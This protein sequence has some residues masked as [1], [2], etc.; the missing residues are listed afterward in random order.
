MYSVLN[1]FQQPFAQLADVWVRF[2]VQPNSNRS[3]LECHLCIVC[4]VPYT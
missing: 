3:P 1:V 2:G 4:A